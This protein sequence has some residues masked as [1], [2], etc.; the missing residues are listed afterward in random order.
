M[1]DLIQR[2]TKLIGKVVPNVEEVLRPMVT[3][4]E[5]NTQVQE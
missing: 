4:K 2:G 3:G 5:R 1:V